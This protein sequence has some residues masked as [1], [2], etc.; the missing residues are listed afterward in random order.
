M[1]YETTLRIA[2]MVDKY[3]IIFFGELSFMSLSLRFI[4][5]II[6]IEKNNVNR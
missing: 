6:E 1:K 3:Q 5:A 4:L 2:K